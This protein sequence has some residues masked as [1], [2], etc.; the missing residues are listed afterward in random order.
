MPMQAYPNW[1]KVAELQAYTELAMAS[2]KQTHPMYFA[3]ALFAHC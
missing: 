3:H 1:R 2:W